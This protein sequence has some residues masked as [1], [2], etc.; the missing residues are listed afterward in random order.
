MP[1]ACKPR[2]FDE[3]IHHPFL[4]A[5]KHTTSPLSVALFAYFMGKANTGPQLRAW[6]RSTVVRW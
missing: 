5:V 3:A 6:C 2:T 1:S 4:E